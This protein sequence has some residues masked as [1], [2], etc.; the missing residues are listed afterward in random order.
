MADLA[1]QDGGAAVIA[2]QAKDSGCAHVDER[3]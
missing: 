2:V 1:A 3:A